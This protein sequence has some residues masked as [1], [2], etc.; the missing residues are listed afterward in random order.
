MELDVLLSSPLGEEGAEMLKATVAKLVDLA[1]WG[2]LC[3][4]QI[5][6]VASEMVLEGASWRPDRATWRFRDVR[7]DPAT[8]CVVLNCLHSFHEDVRPIAEVKL[9]WGEVARLADPL[10]V[11]FPRP[12]PQ[13]PFSLVVGDLEVQ[14]FDIVVTLRQPQE[15][16]R[17]EEIND[18]MGVW[19]SGANL[20]AYAPRGL[21]PSQSGVDFTDEVDHLSADR[22]EWYI[23]ALRCSEASLSGLVNLLQKVHYLVVPVAK[24]QIGDPP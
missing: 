19:V 16:S 13:V 5:P 4:D 2:A 7:L 10:A 3:G 15:A 20:G 8:V 17:V 1:Q 18:I 21:R 9:S 6:P 24:V 23:H 14:Q 11:Q 22:I 12:Y